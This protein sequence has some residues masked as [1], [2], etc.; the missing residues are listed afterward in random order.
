MDKE[1]DRWRTISTA[2]DRCF[3]RYCNNYYKR[4][5]LSSA[6]A[7]AAVGGTNLARAGYSR[8]LLSVARW[9]KRALGWRWCNTVLY[10]SSENNFDDHDSLEPKIVTSFT[11]IS[12]NEHR[13]ADLY[14]ILYHVYQMFI[15]IDFSCWKACPQD[16]LLLVY[17]VSK[18]KPIHTSLLYSKKNLCS[19]NIR[20]FG[21][22]TDRRITWRRPS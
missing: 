6:G 15:I 2:L 14:Y 9:P 17:R 20:I 16:R 7:A 1:H 10:F 11:V 22:A 8:R 18:D 21:I 5:S 12:M 19:R 13:L 4:C 3:G